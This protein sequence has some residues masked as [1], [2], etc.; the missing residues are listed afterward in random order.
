MTHSIYCD[1]A[2]I[3][4][5]LA[6]LAAADY[7]QSKGYQVKVIE[8]Q[9]QVGGRVFTYHVSSDTHFEEGPFSF[10]NGEQPLWGYIERFALPLIKHT[11]ME[12]MFWFN[13]QTGFLSEKGLFLKQEEQKEPLYQLMNI[14]RSKL[15]KLSGDM[16]LTDA[17]QLVG[18]SK[19]AIEWLQ[20]NTLVGLLGNGLHTISMKAALAFL[21][22]YDTSSCFYALKGGNDQLPQAFAK[23]LKDHI[24]L[25]HRVKKIEQLKEKCLLKGEEFTIEAKRVIVAISLLD[26]QK[27]EICPPLSSEKQKAIA[28]ISYTTCTRISMIAPPKIFG[29]EPRGGVFL[30]SDHLGWF[31]DQTIFQIDPTKKNVI[32]VSV[33]GDQ[34]QK[35]STSPEE[36]KKS[37]HEALS[38]LYPDWKPSEV[39][40]HLFTW[41]EG[42][43]YFP[44]HTYDQ[45][46]LLRAIEDRMHF[47]GEHTSQK[48]ASMNGAIESGIRAANEILSIEEL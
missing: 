38:K 36:W 2:V 45:K 31:R 13:N 26:L 30:F 16:S 22:Q 43:A 23:E 28:Q 29:I 6:G 25:N 20:A 17:L 40:S 35:F 4:A 5:G 47:A 11:Q 27:I 24:L 8:A 32:N 18:A 33:V 14:F 37:I 1:I 19:E 21:K 46:D 10:G 44:P 12:R 15:E 42:Y 3:G 34:A 39:E 48:F 41:K 7:L 9:K